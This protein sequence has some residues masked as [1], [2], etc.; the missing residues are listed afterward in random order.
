MRE[1][2]ATSSLPQFKKILAIIANK[3]KQKNFERM[4]A[5]CQLENI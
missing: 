3:F 4:Y 1:K 2:I 5:I